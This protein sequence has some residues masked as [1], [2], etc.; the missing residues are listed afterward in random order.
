MQERLLTMTEAASRVGLKQAALRRA[1][2]RGEIPAAKLCG[3][4]RIRPDALDEWI[5]HNSIVK[6][7][8]STGVGAAGRTSAKIETQTS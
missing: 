8:R 4:I 7:A 1:I 6:S 5:S 3:R 2:Q